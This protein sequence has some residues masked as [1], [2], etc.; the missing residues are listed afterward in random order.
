MSVKTQA[1]SLD[2]DKE[3]AAAASIEGD[4]AVACLVKTEADVLS[5][6]YPVSV[7]VNT[8]THSLLFV[9]VPLH[10]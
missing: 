3:P 6:S 7:C 8:H 2:T 10:D 9:G 1:M 5:P 4:P